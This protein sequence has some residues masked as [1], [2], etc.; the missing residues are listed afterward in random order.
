MMLNRMFF[1]QNDNSIY[2]SYL[3]NSGL[4]IHYL[5]M[6]SFESLLS[7]TNLNR[8]QT[9]IYAHDPVVKTDTVEVFKIH[10]HNDSK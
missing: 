9:W 3:F 6:H 4:T 10:K 1:C 7:M 5:I 8:P 2:I